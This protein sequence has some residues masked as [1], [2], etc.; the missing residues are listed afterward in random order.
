MNKNILYKV[1]MLLGALALT[2][3]SYASIVDWQLN[4]VTFSDGGIA[5]GNFAWDTA[6]SSIVSYHI[7]TSGGNTAN[8]IPTMYDSSNPNDVMNLF[9]DPQP[10]NAIGITDLSQPAPVGSGYRILVMYF[11][12]TLS[13]PIT[14]NP[15][16]ITQSSFHQALECF[17]CN[18]YRLV[19]GGSVSAVPIPAAIWL[20]GSALTG[21][22][23]IGK[24]R[25]TK[26]NV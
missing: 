8:F 9:A 26:V 17:N 2:S 10:N 24:R 14:S 25:S 23:F 21:F 4:G 1:T 16:F 15:V 18:P 13:T 6:T 11:E 5:T 22:G 3:P 12:N 7:S 19:T 20:F